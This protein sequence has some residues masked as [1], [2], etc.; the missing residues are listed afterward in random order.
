MTPSQDHPRP[1]PVTYYYPY[2]GTTSN[3][4]VTGN[5][6]DLGTYLPTA[7]GSSGT[8]YTPEFW[9]PAR[10]AIAVV[11]A[12]PSTFSLDIGQ[13]V[14][15]GYEPDKSSAQIA[16]DYQA[17]AATLT[18]PAW[19]GIFN[20]IPL[21]DAKNAGVLAVVCVW[22][23]LPDDE[24]I[25]QYNPFTTPYPSTSGLATPDDP[26][27]PAVWVGESTGSDLAREAITGAVTATLVLTA[28]VTVGAAT[29]TLWARL[30]GSGS[31]SENMIVN[32]HTDGPNATEE[33]GGLGL[34]ALASYFASLPTRNR[35]L[36]FVLVTGH[37]QLPQFTGAITPT[38]PTVGNDAISV[39]MLDHPAIYQSAVA[40]ITVEH[41]GCTMWQNDPVTGTYAATG[42]YEWSTT[43]TAQR[44]DV[45]NI[46]NIEQNAYLS[47]LTTVNHSGWPNFPTVTV[48]PGAFPLY[49]GEGAPLYAAGLGTV[50][51]I[52]LPT[53]LLQA[54]DA[55]H[56]EQLDLDK[57]DKNL[58]YGQILTCAN[59]IEMLDHTPANSL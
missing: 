49:L 59:T 2:S 51:L 28:E 18:N 20:A 15:G 41:L 46:V 55:Q 42:G 14:T 45:L 56:P 34:L 21:L 54:G 27:C 3:L 38:R 17:Y 22:T 40:G 35:D 24:V 1:V 5:L 39:W 6:I 58:M 13:L 16:A 11:R 25:N 9:A 32:T 26:G 53:Y 4:G 57:L 36:Y 12:A 37:F 30:K 7:A 8:G 50:S 43:Y 47:A 29:E 31:T 33:N 52:P 44:H 10:G 19:Q 23:G 48:L